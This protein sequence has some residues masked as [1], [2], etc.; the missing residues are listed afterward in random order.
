MPVRVNPS[1]CARVTSNVAVQSSSSHAEARD[2]LVWPERAADLSNPFVDLAEKGRGP[3]VAVTVR[4]DRTSRFA[5][6]YEP[7]R[8]FAAQPPPD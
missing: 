2:A 7:Y 8:G 5:R 4:H 1:N 6:S 3:P